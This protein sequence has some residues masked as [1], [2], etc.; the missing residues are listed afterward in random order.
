[1]MRTVGGVRDPTNL[2][3]QEFLGGAGI[4]LG[5]SHLH[6]FWNTSTEIQMKTKS[7]HSEVLQ[8]RKRVPTP[9]ALD[10]FPFLHGG[11]YKVLRVSDVSCAPEQI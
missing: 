8:V 5:P 2:F 10:D 11:D 7:R 6:P 1:M 4:R 9:K 3:I